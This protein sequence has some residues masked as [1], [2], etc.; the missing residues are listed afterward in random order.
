MWDGCTN[1]FFENNAPFVMYRNVQYIRIMLSIIFVGHSAN[2]CIDCIENA[3]TYGIYKKL[4]RM[5]K[6]L[7]EH[8]KHV[9][10]E[11]YDLNKH[12]KRN[13]NISTVYSVNGNISMRCKLYKSY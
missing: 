11:A 8:L 9:T 13:S 12:H 5:I 4:Y 1:I 7:S 3:V 2:Y 10:E 6:L